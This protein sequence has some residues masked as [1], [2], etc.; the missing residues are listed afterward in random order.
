MKTQMDR[1]IEHLGNLVD[2][3]MNLCIA[4]WN[5]VRCT[6]PANHEPAD[7]HKFPIEFWQ[8]L[9]LLEDSRVNINSCH[10]YKNR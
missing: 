1:E 3:C 8:A 4:E 10:E 9:A 6:L 7:G 2:R 5:G